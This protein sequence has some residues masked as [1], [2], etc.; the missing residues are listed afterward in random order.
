MMLS[1]HNLKFLTLTLLSTTAIYS[2]AGLSFGDKTTTTGQLDISGAV[3]AKYIYNFDTEP[4]TSKLSFND[5]LLWIDYTS[6]KWLGRIDY[7]AYEYYGHVGDASW[8]HNA[9]IGYKFDDHQKLIAGLNPVPFGSGRFWGS[10]YYLGIGN[11]LGLEDVHNLGLKYEYSQAPY[12]FQAAFYPRDGGNYHGK[13]KDA[14][15]F[16][17]NAVEADDASNGTYTQEKNSIVLRGAYTLKDVLGQKDL[18]TQLGASVW[19][20]TLENKRNH[21]DGDRQVY[22]V[23]ANNNYKN[24]N[25]QVLAGYQNINNKDDVFAN[26]TT[27]GA[28]DYSFN[29]ANKGQ[30][31]SSELSYAFPQ[32]WGD[33]NGFKPY[34]NYS[35]YLKDQ[36]GFKDTQ[37]IIT[38]LAFN[39]KKLTVNSELLLGK[40]DPYLGDAEGLAQG[41]GDGDWNKRLFVSLA[42][43]F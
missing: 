42:Y 41:S 10:T 5:A 16:S 8:L 28:F 32:Q 30:F 3:R 40:H 20:S 43:Y 25:L 27:F 4:S 23:F 38:G 7:R 24:W 36:A 11:V 18:S 17:V 9:W 29:A 35:A 34:V 37:R 33:F 14:S 15:R 13:S 26:F 1:K 31:Y 39:Y 6:P 21:K 22:A 19:H 12:E 2:H